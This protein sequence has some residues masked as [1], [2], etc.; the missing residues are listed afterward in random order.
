MNKK[1][2]SV[3]KSERPKKLYNDVGVCIRHTTDGRMIQK[4]KY[5]TE[6]DAKTTYK[7]LFA[8]GVANT[9]GEFYKCPTCKMFHYGTP[10]DIKE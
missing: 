10:E 8:L 3:P 1:R 7:K 6:E 2:R 9:S 4:S 5:K